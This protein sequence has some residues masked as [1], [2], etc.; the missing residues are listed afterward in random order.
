LEE[1]YLY[2][3]SENPFIFTRTYEIKFNCHFDLHDY[4]F[5]LQTCYILVNII[6]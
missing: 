3:G 4:P 2:S 6:I 1:K 5:D